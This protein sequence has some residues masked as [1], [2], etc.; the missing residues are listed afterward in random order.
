M[1]K[2]LILFVII[3]TASLSCT[4]NTTEKAAGKR[5]VTLSN[6]PSS[7]PYSPAVEAGNMLF[8][9]GQIAV[10]PDTGRLIEGG[11]E[12]QTRQVLVNL[13][14]VIESAG[15]KLENVVKCTV[16]MTDITHYQVM[17]KIYME[18]FPSDPPARAAFAVEDLPMGALIEIEAVAVR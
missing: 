3:L 10:D 13:R 14:K 1:R 18:F 17:N 16:L 15:Y 2:I 6:T 11:I 4:D 12:E 7:R 8:V 5:V 9:S